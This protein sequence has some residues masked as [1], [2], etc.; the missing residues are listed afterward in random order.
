MYNELWRRT[1]L[2]EGL[3]KDSM[4]LANATRR[5]LQE[6]MRSV[7]MQLSRYCSLQADKA[8]P[9]SHSRDNIEATL[10]EI[11][12]STSSY[13]QTIISIQH[14]FQASCHRIQEHEPML[15]KYL[16][17]TLERIV[18]LLTNNKWENQVEDLHRYL[19]SHHTTVVRNVG[20][21]TNTVLRAAN[22]SSKEAQ[23]L[24][25][26]INEAHEGLLISTTDI[27]KGIS[28]IQN[29]QQIVYQSLK[30]I[31]AVMNEL[32]NK[33]SYSSNQSTSEGPYLKVIQC[34]ESSTE[35][36]NITSE[37]KKIFEANHNHLSKEI[38]NLTQSITEVL[39]N[40]GVQISSHTSDNSKSSKQDLIN[41]LTTTSEDYDDT[42]EHD[43]ISETLEEN[44]NSIF[45]S[46]S[47]EKS[48]VF[49]NLTNLQTMPAT[50]KKSIQTQIPS[51]VETSTPQ[52]STPL[53]G[54]SSSQEVTSIVSNA[55]N[56]IRENQSRDNNERVS[57]T[58]QENQINLSAPLNST[59]ITIVHSAE[60]ITSEDQVTYLSTDNI[61][62]VMSNPENEHLHR[63]TFIQTEHNNKFIASQ[64][65]DLHDTNY[66]LNE[67]TTKNPTPYYQD[68]NSS[69]SSRTEEGSREN[70]D[71]NS[72]FPH[73]KPQTQ[74]YNHHSNNNMSSHQTLQKN[75]S[76]DDRHADDQNLPPMNNPK[77]HSQREIHHKFP[78]T[79]RSFP[80]NTRHK[81][82][83]KNDTH[84]LYRLLNK[85]EELSNRLMNSESS[86][87][88]APDNSGH[89]DDSQ[90]DS[91]ENLDYSLPDSTFSNK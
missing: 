54:T 51:Q 26:A 23:N 3:A 18:G 5:E 48:S 17:E 74:D 56:E 78:N 15:E 31:T 41:V 57:N 14:M 52:P 55:H 47:S 27:Q 63:Q 88:S 25:V 44:L 85:L 76:Q 84:Y 75:A 81:N 91:E 30:E 53:Y 24:A 2:L 8:K 58:T 59:I 72:S 65:L 38:Q 39:K 7:S 46:H 11:R 83:N 10:E 79:N 29:E 86:D 33:V 6:G 22:Y 37:L 19:K 43:S 34:Q 69:L 68:I 4:A 90:E 73:R 66:A 87:G 9:A 64:K 20:H 50:N 16:A 1:Q 70:R 89:T 12:T 62:T 60:P 40:L 77:N 28:K 71:R 80:R 82:F 36:T 49:Q 45:D 61:S 35:S 67:M 21:T 42:S 32:E 13:F